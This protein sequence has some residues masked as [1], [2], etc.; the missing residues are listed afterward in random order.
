M[1][2]RGRR[3]VC[4]P[5]VTQHPGPILGNSSVPGPVHVC[6]VVSA[7]Y[8]YVAAIFFFSGSDPS[9]RLRNEHGPVASNLP[10]LSGASSTDVEL[11][12]SL[13][14]DAKESTSRL[15]VLRSHSKTGYLAIR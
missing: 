13:G 11:R 8:S 6:V 9:S 4:R 2:P 15:H 7:T 3:L 10:Y 1:L 5:A 12:D 14:D